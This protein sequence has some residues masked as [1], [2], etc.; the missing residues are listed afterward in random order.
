MLS[1]EHN[2]DYKN[3]AE[4]IYKYDFNPLT[5][6]VAFSQIIMFVTPP[7]GVTLKFFELHY[8]LKIKNVL[9]FMHEMF[10]EIKWIDQKK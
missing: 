8:Y 7:I 3:K 6:D 5:T 10:C 4:I 2:K 1:S 9:V